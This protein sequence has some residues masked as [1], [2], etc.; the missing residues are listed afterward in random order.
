MTRQYAIGG[1]KAS[2][3]TE[4]GSTYDSALGCEQDYDLFHAKTQRTIPFTNYDLI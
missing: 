2:V 4:G 1:R 3:G